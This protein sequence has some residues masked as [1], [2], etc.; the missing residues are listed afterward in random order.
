MSTLADEAGN[1][2]E[3]E[4]SGYTD[5]SYFASASSSSTALRLP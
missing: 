1:L 5:A 4:M 2:E 3:F